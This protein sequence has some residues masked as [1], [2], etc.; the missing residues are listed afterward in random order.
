[1]NRP[2]SSGA[3]L[4]LPAAHSTPDGTRGTMPSL[5]ARACATMLRWAR[6]R[7]ARYELAQLDERLLRDVGLTRQQVER[8]RSKPFWRA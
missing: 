4:P 7:R 1:M 3:A 6:R 2:H 5:L 8:E